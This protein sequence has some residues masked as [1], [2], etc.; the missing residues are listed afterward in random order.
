M[1][2]RQCY[3]AHIYTRDK[4]GGRNKIFAETTN[5]RDYARYNILYGIKSTTILHIIFVGKKT[6][7]VDATLIAVAVTL[8]RAR[9]GGGDG[10][11]GGGGN[12]GTP[13]DVHCG[14]CV[15]SGPVDACK[16]AIPSVCVYARRI[17]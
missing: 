2:A 3:N 4:T 9:P 11:G 1:S 7:T 6:N 16:Y 13:D 12:G 5:G 8:V 14:G 15:C 17:E 10:S